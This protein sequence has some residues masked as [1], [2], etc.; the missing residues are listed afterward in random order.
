MRVGETP[1]RLG[2]LLT[3]LAVA[4]CTALIFAVPALHE[5]VGNALQGDTDQL[6]SDLREHSA[7]R[8]ILIGVIV[9]HAIVWYPAEIANAAAGVVYGFWGAILLVLPAWLAAN[10]GAYAIGRH[11]GRPL[12]HKLVGRERFGRAEAAIERGGIP[13][14][15]ASR[16]IPVMPMSIVGYVA[17]AARV[18]LVPFAW[19]TFVGTLPLTAAA[20][21]LGSRIDELSLTDPVLYLITVPFLILLALSR[22]LARRMRLTGTLRDREKAG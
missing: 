8:L 19:T 15:L 16:L 14:L 9:A 17:G 2:I 12:L 22:P 7:G 13:A 1:G 18:P 11:A 5:A 20:V 21:L 4:L 10:L 6:R 3:L